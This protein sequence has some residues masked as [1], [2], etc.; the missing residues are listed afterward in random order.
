MDR[1]SIGRSS[2]ATVSGSP[3]KGSDFG[4]L[5]LGFSDVC[6]QNTWLS[7]R[8]WS[9]KVIAPV[10]PF[11]AGRISALLWAYERS[12]LRHR[13]LREPLRSRR[14]APRAKSSEQKR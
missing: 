5:G 9:V 6:L 10:D 2:V 3:A 8:L 11:L 7:G 1:R 4:S 12:A 14:R 13:I